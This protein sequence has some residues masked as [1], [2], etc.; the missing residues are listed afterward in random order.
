MKANLLTLLAV[1]LYITSG[2]LTGSRLFAH[3]YKPDSRMLPLSLGF[4][5]LALHAVVLYQGT[6]LSDGYNLGLFNAFSMVAFAIIAILLLSSLTKPV[7]NLGIILLPMAALTLIMQL[8]FPGIQLLS[9]HA[10]W[11]LKLHVLISILAYSLLTLASVQAIL[12]AVLDK[13][14]RTH[15]T[16]TFVRAMPPLQTMESLLFEMIAVGFILLSAALLTC[17]IYLEDVFAQHLVHKTALSI[18]SWVFFGILL[19]GRFQFGWRGKTAIRWTLGGFATLMLAYFGSKFVLE[20]LL[21]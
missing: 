21:R 17:I 6:I 11:G 5:A 15:R 7:E 19:W 1:V 9:A 20:I 8:R 3:S 2:F 10:G 14:L 18:L 12:L 13:R 16:G 4:A